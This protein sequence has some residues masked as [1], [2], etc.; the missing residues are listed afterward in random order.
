MKQIKTFQFLKNWWE[1]VFFIKCQH[2][3]ADTFK[4]VEKFHKIFQNTKELIRTLYKYTQTKYLE[5]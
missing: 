4:L 5:S 3:K 1:T 2:K